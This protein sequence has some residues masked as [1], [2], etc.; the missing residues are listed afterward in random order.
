M[1]SPRIGVR[2]AKIS[3][4]AGVD[5]LCWCVVSFFLTGTKSRGAGE[6]NYPQAVPQ[7]RDVPG[8]KVVVSV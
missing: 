6:M 5:I 1:P 8:P 3:I 4:V 2:S 7:G